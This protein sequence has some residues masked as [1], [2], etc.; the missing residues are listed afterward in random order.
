MV[1][2]VACK[3]EMD[4]AAGIYV[5]EHYIS[6]HR[7]QVE[8]KVGFSSF[9]SLSYVHPGC[10]ES[11]DILDDKQFRKWIWLTLTQQKKDADAVRRSLSRIENALLALPEEMTAVFRD[12]FEHERTT[13]GDGG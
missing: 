11:I 10:V 2:C 8:R 3:G 7:L 4:E 1:A 12:E 13:Y 9:H 6:R 5:S